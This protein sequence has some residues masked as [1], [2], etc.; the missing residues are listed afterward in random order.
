VDFCAFRALAFIH[1]KPLLF[2]EVCHSCGGCK[3]LCPANAIEEIGE[4]IGEISIGHHNDVMVLSGMMKTGKSSGTPII[5]RLQE[6]LDEYDNEI[7]IIDCPPGAA[8][9]VM[10]SIV[11]ADFCLLVAEPTLFGMD[12]LAMVYELVQK[13]HKPFGVVLNK[14]TE[15]A[16]PSEDFCKEHQIPILGRIPF[17]KELGSIASQGG[18]V[19]EE[20]PRYEALFA[21]ILAQI[22][23]EVAQ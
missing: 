12:N 1:K 22:V 7:K 3:V 17:D 14:C 8:C 2:N 6:L 5:K 21:N 18:I 19:A 20:L 13:F 10:E 9:I 23:Q 15:G 4:T 16:N 11:N